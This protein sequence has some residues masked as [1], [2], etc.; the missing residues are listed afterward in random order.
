MKEL[1]FPG[2]MTLA[3]DYGKRRKIECDDF[4]LVSSV[5]NTITGSPAVTGNPTITGNVTLT[6]NLTGNGNITRTGNIALT[7]NE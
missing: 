4:I 5:S 7:G 1:Q 2:K 6:G 3:Y